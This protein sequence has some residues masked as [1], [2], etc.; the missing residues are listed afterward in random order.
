MDVPG[1]WQWVWGGGRDVEAEQ[2]GA[3]RGAGQR[4][5]G[6]RG[7]GVGGGLFEGHQVAEEFGVPGC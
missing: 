4:G 5:G 3:A 1:S 7:G 2:P 6:R